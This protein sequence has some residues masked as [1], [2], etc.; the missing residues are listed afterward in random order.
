[1][2]QPPDENLIE[3]PSAVAL[4]PSGLESLVPVRPSA[5]E[6][7]GSALRTVG[8]VHEIMEALG[9]PGVLACI[10]PQ[11]LVDPSLGGIRRQIES[12]A[13]PK[14]DERV[15]GTFS[16]VRA[17]LCDLFGVHA[18][19]GSGDA[20]LM[21]VALHLAILRR[22][23]CEDRVTVQLSSGT[24]SGK[25]HVDGS[26]G[27]RSAVRLIHVYAGAPTQFIHPEE[28]SSQ[29]MFEGYAEGVSGY[30]VRDL[31]VEGASIRSVPVDATVAIKLFDP[32]LKRQGWIH[33]TPPGEGPRLVMT[34]TAPVAF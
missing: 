7:Q 8:S 14:L 16:A 29:S 18:G 25:F 31:L 27:A 9:E 26:D 13:G 11:Q 19:S 34:V 32:A 12:G 2:L 3:M 15:S 30:K 33:R 23:A 1:M 6:S 17:E 21:D 5:L 20:L 10:A 24:H 22:H 4:N 28:L